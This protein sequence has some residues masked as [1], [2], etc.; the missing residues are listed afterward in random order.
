[1]EQFLQTINGGFQR[2]PR[3]YSNDAHFHLHNPSPE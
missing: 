2:F 3:V 1:M